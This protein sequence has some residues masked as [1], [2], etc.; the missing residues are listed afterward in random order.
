MSLFALKLI[1]IITMT[2]DHVGR[3]FFPAEIEWLL[4]GRLAFPLFAWGIANGYHHTSNVQKY[5]TRIGIF[6]VI[7]QIPFT[8]T[9][10][11]L[12]YNPTVMNIFFTLLLGLLA[13]FSYDKIKYRTVGIT[14]VFLLSVLASL[15][16]TDYGA[17]GVLITFVFYL[18]YNKP[19]Q[20]LLYQFLLWFGLLA[21][22]QVALSTPF[23]SVVID[24]Y[25]SQ[26]IVIQVVALLSVG[27]ISLYNGVQGPRLKWLF[28]WY[29]P[30][31]LTILLIIATLI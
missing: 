14:I 12:R 2:I 31:H 13:I 24:N 18:T 9:Y 11:T 22:S 6:A 10:L 23:A 8:L 21:L 28:Y 20:M 1:A 4:V 3:F 7:S 26:T 5:L 17:Y 25:V 16:P 27:L 19:K 30:V 15:V 29:Y